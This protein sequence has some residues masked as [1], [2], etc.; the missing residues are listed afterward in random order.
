MGYLRH[1][2]HYTLIQNHL[3]LATLDDI[4]VLLD[5][6]KNFHK[7]SPY[8]GMRF[9][10]QKGIDFLKGIITGSKTEGVV[11]VAL[12]DGEPIGMLV[13]ACTEPVFTSARVAMELGWWI[14]PEFRSTRA[15]LLIYTAYE[16]WAKRV[17]CS[18]VQG[19]YLTGISPELDKFYKKRGYTQVESSYLK[20]LKVY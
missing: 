16:D 1:W 13:G 3:R 12:K 20:T 7:V 8:R 19:A 14:E 5:F 18:H 17:G 10:T 15:S 6:A 11:L 9:N 4:P 2:R